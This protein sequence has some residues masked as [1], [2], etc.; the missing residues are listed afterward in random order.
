MEDLETVVSGK[1]ITRHKKKKKKVDDNLYSNCFPANEEP[2]IAEEFVPLGD[3]S[4]AKT[5]GKGLLNARVI[6]VIGELA[7]L[8]GV[9]DLIIFLCYQGAG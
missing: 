5:G 7:T 8:L 1:P 4:L 9:N 6:F 2:I 3:Q